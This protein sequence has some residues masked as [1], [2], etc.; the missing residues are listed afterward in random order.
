MEM[1]MPEESK[2]Q[3]DIIAKL[4]NMMEMFTQRITQLENK[5]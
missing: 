2:T 3:N 4:F 5:I 1:E